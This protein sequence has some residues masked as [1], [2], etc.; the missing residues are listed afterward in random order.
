MFLRPAGP[1]GCATRGNAAHK[2]TISVDLSEINNQREKKKRREPQSEQEEA[3]TLCLAQS[4][5]QSSPPPPPLPHTLGHANF[6]PP[7]CLP[8]FGRLF[9]CGQSSE[10]FPPGPV[11]V[12]RLATSG[13]KTNATFFLSA[14]TKSNPHTPTHNWPYEYWAQ[15]CCCD[16]ADL[17]MSADGNL[18][19]AIGAFL[20]ETG[21]KLIIKK[22]RL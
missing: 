3:L 16:L 4:V 11:V 1:L 8:T 9:V 18:A 7:V 19:L 2:M 13:L 15:L 5:P 10:L 17:A 14:N 22:G 20:L 21:K 6:L 12:V